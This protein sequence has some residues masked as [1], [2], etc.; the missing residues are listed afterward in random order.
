MGFHRPRQR[1]SDFTASDGGRLEP[2]GTA[3]GPREQRSI[4]DGTPQVTQD[5]RPAYSAAVPNAVIP[6][7]YSG[8]VARADA[9]RTR[10]QSAYT[11][12][13]AIAVGLIGTAIIGQLDQQ[14]LWVRVLGIGS[15]VAWA[16]VAATFVY[17]ICVPA[18]PPPAAHTI[19]GEDAAVNE[20]I[21]LTTA[22]KN[23]V[24]WRARIARYGAIAS[25]A[26][27]LAALGGVVFHPP[28]MIDAV[29]V[30]TPAEVAIAQQ[31][32]PDITERIEAQ[33]EVSTLDSDFLVVIPDGSLCGTP[34]DALRIPTSSVVAEEAG[35]S[36]GAF[37]FP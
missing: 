2:Q 32:C 6:A 29:V 30:I 19:I 28:A 14:P 7:F 26:I 16:V 23:N 31:A 9:A 37:P 25:T 20:I 15:I 34:G 11:I 21:R 36:D 33:V 24:E 8:I 35:P 10:A 4:P 18:Q 5:P 22:E 17:A 3:G 12:A 1:M 27:T 13:S